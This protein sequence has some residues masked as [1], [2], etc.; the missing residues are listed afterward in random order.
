MG[1]QF[2]NRLNAGSSDTAWKIPLILNK[3]PEEKLTVSDS[4]PVAVRA[5]QIIGTNSPTLGCTIHCKVGRP[6]KTR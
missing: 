5:A 4:L 6:E 2:A 3:R 1:I